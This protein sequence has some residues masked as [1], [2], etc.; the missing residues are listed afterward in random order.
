MEWKFPPALIIDVQLDEE[1]QT[2]VQA[3]E[4]QSRTQRK[5]NWIS[6][7]LLLR[8]KPT[9]QKRKRIRRLQLQM[10]RL[11]LKRTGLRLHLLQTNLLKWQKL[12]P[13]RN[14][15]RVTVQGADTVVTDSTEK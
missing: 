11:K 9:K 13:G 4:Q 8:E 12:K 10:Q 15:A 6:R 3:K 1:L 14:I 7:P 5:R 2:K